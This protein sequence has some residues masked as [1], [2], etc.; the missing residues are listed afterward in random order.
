MAE[1][2]SVIRGYVRLTPAVTVDRAELGLAPGP[3]T[4][5]LEHSGSFKVRGAFANLLLREIPE[6]GVA[7]ASGGNHGAACSFR[8][9]AGRS[10]SQAM[11]W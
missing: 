6:A 2:E 11:S 8:S 5:K 9:A 3:L 1:V 10:R 7:A 4:L